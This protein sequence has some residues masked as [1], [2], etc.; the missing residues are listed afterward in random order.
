MSPLSQYYYEIDQRIIKCEE[1]YYIILKEQAQF[2]E[3]DKTILI[4]NI[5]KQKQ[6][7]F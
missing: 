4:L 3:K 1:N 6:K 5:H 7:E 2:T